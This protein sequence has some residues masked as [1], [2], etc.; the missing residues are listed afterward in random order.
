MLFVNPPVE[1]PQYVT[2]ETF[3]SQVLSH[4][5]G[6]NIYLPP[7]YEDSSDKYPVVYHIHG[8]KGNE[9]FRDMATGKGL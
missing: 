4:D 5:L 3:Y 7:G 8:W 9:F 6:Y 1:P 2:H